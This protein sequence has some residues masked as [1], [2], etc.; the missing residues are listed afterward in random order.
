M[1]QTSFT[2]YATCATAVLPSMV[3]TRGAISALPPRL[4]DHVDG[5]TGALFEAGGTAGA[6]VI[7]DTITP[8][9]SELDDGGL[10]TGGKAV[11]AFVAVAAGEAALRF[12]ARF[13]LGQ[14][15]HDFLEAAQPF[16]HGQGL[17]RARI[18]IAVDR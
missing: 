3:A 2:R 13:V 4:G 9:K 18:G 15:G 7:G 14:A 10:R 12:V 16:G 6:S 8:A 17:L 1:A 5:V 11:V